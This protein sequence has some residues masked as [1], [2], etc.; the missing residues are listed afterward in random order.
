[1]VRA[2]TEPTFTHIR[3]TCRC[4]NRIRVDLSQPPQRLM[5]PPPR[6]HEIG[7]SAHP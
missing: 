7:V 5:L 6:H 4:G 1:M 3:L 2:E